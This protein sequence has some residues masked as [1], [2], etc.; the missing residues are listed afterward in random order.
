[1]TIGLLASRPL[2]DCRFPTVVEPQLYAVGFALSGDPF[3]EIEAG[4]R[5]PGVRVGSFMKMPEGSTT[6]LTANP[7]T[8]WHTCGLVGILDGFR[9]ALKAL[10]DCWAW[11]DLPAGTQL[12]IHGII[13]VRMSC[14][15]DFN[16]NQEAKDSASKCLI[17]H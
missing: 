7:R 14:P 9:K 17:I 5:Q 3:T 13:I 12:S 1:M 6:V 15:T 8:H 16:P 2:Y 11:D 10:I 4:K